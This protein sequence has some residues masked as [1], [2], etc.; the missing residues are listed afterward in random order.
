MG[1]PFSRALWH[2]IC[3]AFTAEAQ[4]TQRTAEDWGT[5][6]GRYPQMTQMGADERV[7]GGGEKAVQSLPAE[8]SGDLSVGAQ[9]AKSE[10]GSNLEL[11]LMRRGKKQDG[12]RKSPGPGNPQIPGCSKPT[13]ISD[14]ADPTPAMPVTSLE[15]W[16][17]FPGP[18]CWVLYRRHTS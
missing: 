1:W 17:I 11:P 3:T 12:G 18:G 10:G 4:S 9:R 13:S 15:L 8:A 2:G 14:F 7:E 16:Q 6:D 5:A